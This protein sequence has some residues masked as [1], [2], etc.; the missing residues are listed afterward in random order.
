MNNYLFTKNN[1]IRN[2]NNVNNKKFLTANYNLCFFIII[3]LFAFSGKCSDG[4]EKFR[5]EITWS[6]RHST[7]E[8]RVFR[9]WSYSV[10]SR[11]WSEYKKTFYSIDLHGSWRFLAEFCNKRRLSIRLYF[12]HVYYLRTFDWV[13]RFWWFLLYLKASAS[14][15]VP[16]F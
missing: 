10:K 7:F 3:K 2:K 6:W 13:N 4:E 14:R 9:P 8:F 15:E 1:G 16:F 11:S 12:L 5:K